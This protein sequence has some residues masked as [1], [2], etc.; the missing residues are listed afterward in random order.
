MI[1][2]KT[3]YISKEH[4]YQTFASAFY[5]EPARLNLWIKEAALDIS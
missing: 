3:V 1:M 4:H 5:F 2:A